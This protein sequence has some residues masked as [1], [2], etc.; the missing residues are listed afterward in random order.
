[1]KI[2][3]GEERETLY[4]EDPLVFSKFRGTFRLHCWIRTIRPHPLN[5][6]YRTL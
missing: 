5:L 1:M 6:G 3:R 2:D 4:I